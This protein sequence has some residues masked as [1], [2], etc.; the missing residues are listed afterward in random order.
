MQKPLLSKINI[1]KRFRHV[2]DRLDYTKDTWNSIIWT[3]ETKIRLVRSDGRSYV[4]RKV[5]SRYGMKNSQPTV[6]LWFGGV[7]LPKE[8]E[9]WHSSMGK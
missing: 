5:G 6:V 4:R 3:D 9:D 1:D 2:K 8:L 7:S